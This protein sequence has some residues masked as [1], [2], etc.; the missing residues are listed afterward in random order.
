MIKSA[1]REF[2]DSDVTDDLDQTMKMVMVKVIVR[3]NS[4]QCLVA[5]QVH[6][7]RR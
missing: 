4:I 3:K 1:N 6:G 5:E 7:H 2:M